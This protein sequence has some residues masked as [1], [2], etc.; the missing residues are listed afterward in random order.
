MSLFRRKKV[1][2]ETPKIEPT[3]I[4]PKS[5]ADY[6]KRGYA[7]YAR[8]NY[9]KASEDILK[10]L[11]MDSQSI[12]AFYALGL[13]HKAQDRVDDAVEAFQ[14]ALNRVSA[15]EK[16]DSIRAHMLSRLIKG[17]INQLTKGDWDLRKEFW[18]L[19]R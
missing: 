2:I 9:E 18:E 1:E 5:A 19:E 8:G 13:N 12:E 6:V 16:V 14:N 3:E 11:S 15:L 10:A 4:E 17:H 7:Y